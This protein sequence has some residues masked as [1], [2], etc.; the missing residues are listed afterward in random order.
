MF[1]SHWSNA[2]GDKK[3]LICHVTSQNYVI[4]GS[5][6]FMSGSSLLHANTL[7]SLLTLGL[8]TVKI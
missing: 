7:P 3:Y 1:G 2:S 6:N 5:C 8:V 4:E